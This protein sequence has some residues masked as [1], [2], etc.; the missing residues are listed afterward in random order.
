MGPEIFAGGI[1]NSGSLGVAESMQ[2]IF[3]RLLRNWLNAVC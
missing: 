2:P 1:V 3:D